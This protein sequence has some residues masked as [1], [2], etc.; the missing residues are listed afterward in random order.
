MDDGTAERKRRRVLPATL[1]T[2]AVAAVLAAALMISLVPAHGFGPLLP[3]GRVLREHARQ[4]QRHR[5]DPSRLQDFVGP[6]ISP[7][8]PGLSG[9]EGGEGGGRRHSPATRQSPRY[10][11]YRPS[12]K[13][14]PR[15]FARPSARPAERPGARPSPRRPRPWH[16]T[17]NP[18]RNGLHRL[19]C[20]IFHRHC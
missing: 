10:P 12:A 4:Q 6:E 5:D 13:P 18:L 7:N 20:K 1:G 16:H 17:R 19:S 15:P 14:S 3:V 11:A 8:R 2:L 9:G